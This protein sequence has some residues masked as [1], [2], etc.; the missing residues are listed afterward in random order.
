[1][2]KEDCE[3]IECWLGGCWR[4]S[5]ITPARD[6]DIAELERPRFHWDNAESMC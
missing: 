6:E 5:L 3:Y 4:N 1:M 2:W